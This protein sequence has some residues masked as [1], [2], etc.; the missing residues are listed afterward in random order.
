MMTLETLKARPAV[1]DMRTSQL[2]REFADIK[3]NGADTAAQAFSLAGRAQ[4]AR[5]DQ[6]VAELRSR[7]VLD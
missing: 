2:V 6:V 4:H 3:A 1:S 5:L 7:C